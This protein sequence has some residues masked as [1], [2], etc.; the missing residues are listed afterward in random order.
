MTKL[1]P[2]VLQTRVA[3]RL[4][5]LFVMSALVPLAAIAI[6]SLTQVRE[7]LLQQGDERLMATAKNLGME[8]FARLVRAAEVAEAAGRP[9]AAPAADPAVERVFISLARAP[10]GGGVSPMAGGAVNVT[11]PV[12]V[13]KRAAQGESSLFVATAAG[14]PAVFVG[15]PSQGGLVFG[16]VRPGYLWGAPDEVPHATDFCVMEDASR[17]FLHCYAPG[18]SGQVRALAELPFDVAR[19][20]TWTRDG[21]T[22]RGRAWAQ[23]MGAKFGAPDWIVAASQPEALSLRR[24][25]RFQQ[26]YVPAIALALVLVSWFTLRQ[27]RSIVVPLSRLAERARELAAGRFA[28]RVGMTRDDEFGELASAFD[29]MSSRLGQQFASLR[30]LSEIDSL[31]LSGEDTTQVIRSVVQR[32][33][34]L[35]TAK[36]VTLSTVDGSSLRTYYWVGEGGG[37]L[38]DQHPDRA[39]EVSTLALEPAWHALPLPEPVPKWLA[40]PG[41]K[42]MRGALAQPIVWQGKPHGVIVLGYES[43]DPPPQEERQHIAEMADRMAVA[44]STAWRD[45]QIYQRTHFDP[46]TGSPNRLLFSDRLGVEIV[47]SAREDVRFAVMVVNLDRFKNVNESL[48]HSVGDLVLREAYARIG[49]SLRSEDTLARLGSD[50]FAVLVANVANA[51]EAWL[52]AETILAQMAREFRVGE[53]RVFLSAS[54]GIASFPADGSSAEDLLKS[55]DIAMHRAKEGGRSQALFFEERMNAEVVAALTLDRDLRGALERGELQVH[56]QPQVELATGRIVSAE[57]LLRW[58]HPT[59]GTISPARFIPLAEESGFIEVI[60]EWLFEEVCAQVATWRG[61]GL[62][63]E[64]VAVNVSPRQL[65]RRDFAATVAACARKHGVAASAVQIEIT[66]GLLLDRGTVVEELF[67]ELAEAGHSIALDDFGTGFSSMAYLERLPVDTIKIDQTFIRNLAVG[68][69]SRSIVSAIIAMSHA[70]GKTVV[71][72]GVETEAQAE[73]LRQLGCHRIQGYLVS[74]AVHAGAFSRLAHESAAEAA[75]SA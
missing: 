13:L 70:L 32:L 50:E 53:Q 49:G 56:Y 59:R 35:T 37:F 63:L 46:L 73:L 24:L 25:A 8:F 29:A 69:D 75:R 43:P 33:G 6:V 10:E 31:M 71:A 22:H 68:R 60:G 11:P 57:A 12:A 3:R 2:A 5:T 28:G 64:H 67:R 39:S 1:F 52:I 26:I 20:S 15:A 44:V 14:G 72:E 16:Q 51:Q 61:E 41:Y 21:E 74:P 65:R 7:L 45:E 66:E 47:R 34:E 54:V 36:L 4:F 17:V 42:A 48:G 58:F 9:G 18:G 19:T 55:A 40:H 30:T 23:F 62:E 38:L 27:S